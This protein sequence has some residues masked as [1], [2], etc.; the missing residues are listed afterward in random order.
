MGFSQTL[1]TTYFVRLD[2]LLTSIQNSLKKSHQKKSGKKLEDLISIGEI[3]IYTKTTY[4]QYLSP[5]SKKILYISEDPI[6]LAEGISIE[7]EDLQRLLLEKSR[8]IIDQRTSFLKDIYSQ[9][10]S[11][12]DRLKVT[13][14]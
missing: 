3:N 2:N 11:F 8:K 14:R 7:K 1:E 10:P 5:K 9:E 4:H 12:E 13:N 6:F